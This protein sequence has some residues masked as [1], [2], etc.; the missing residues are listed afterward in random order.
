MLSGGHSRP[1]HKL[2]GSLKYQFQPSG[3]WREFGAL[4]MLPKF[5]VNTVRFGAET[6]SICSC[7]FMIWTNHQSAY[8]AL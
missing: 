5:G 1:A 8:C 6:S 4:E 3:S 7:S 2:L